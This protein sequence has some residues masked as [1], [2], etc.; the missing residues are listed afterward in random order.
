MN[1]IVEN[2]LAL[3]AAVPAVYG[4]VCWVRKGLNARRTAKWVKETHPEEWN[5]LH[6]LARRNSWAGVRALITMG[7]ISGPRV[8]EFIA[9]DEY[10]E[11]ATWLGLLASA[12]L[13]LVIVAGK[14]AI[15]GSF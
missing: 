5:G 2:I 9:R 14:Y 15:T 7:L 12:V 10:L 4:L 3:V 6:W 1:T 8:D 13:L 11:K